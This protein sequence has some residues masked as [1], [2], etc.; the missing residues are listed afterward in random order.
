MFG[1]MGQSEMLTFEPNE[2]SFP[3]TW[4][5]VVGAGAIAFTP[6]SI[7]VISEQL[8]ETALGEADRTV[9]GTE[10]HSPG[11]LFGLPCPSP[12]VGVRSTALGS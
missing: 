7:Y 8:W 3:Q 6:Y 5:L 11:F 2:I 1:I 4:W 10:T 12:R 9:T